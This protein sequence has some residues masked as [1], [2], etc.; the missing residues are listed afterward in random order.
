MRDRLIKAA[1]IFKLE[2]KDF[3]SKRQKTIRFFG[4]E[5]LK[6]PFPFLSSVL[7]LVAVYSMFFSFSR[8]SL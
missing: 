1:L 3:S 7:F 6:S 8:N 4:K 5:L 2:E